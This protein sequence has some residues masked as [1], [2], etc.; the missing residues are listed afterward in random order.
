[1]TYYDKDKVY[2]RDKAFSVAQPQPISHV[3]EYDLNLRRFIF[4]LSLKN[5]PVLYL[6]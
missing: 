2:Q 1:M 6:T 3:L 4:V 5:I